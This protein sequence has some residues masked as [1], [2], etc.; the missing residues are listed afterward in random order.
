[1]QFAVT[2]LPIF[3]VWQLFCL[4]PFGLTK[5]GLKVSRENTHRSIVIVCLIIHTIIL[6]HGLVYSSYFIGWTTSK[7]TVLN[8]SNLISLTSTRS[9]TILIIIESFVK[10]STQIHFLEKIS[11]IDSILTYK[12]NI[13][14]KFD[15]YRQSNLIWSTIWLLFFMIDV[16]AVFVFV[17]LYTD[18]YFLRLWAA[19]AI[20]FFICSLRY[21]QMVTYV[22]LIRNRY[23]II[24]EVI[25]DI[26]K[27]NNTKMN[28][29]DISLT[30]N[31]FVKK[32]QS[33]ANVDQFII[34]KKLNDLREVYQLLYESTEYI[35]DIFRWSLPINI[36]IGFHEALVNTYFVFVCL[37]SPKIDLWRQ[38]AAGILTA[39]YHFMEIIA[40]SDTC[41][42][43]SEEVS[44][45]FFIF[46]NK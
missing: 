40:L 30:A 14:I 38:I 46:P 37:I 8:Y 3:R 42:Y 12:L 6:I 18:E 22:M 43:S 24:N 27:T 21:H 17:Y 2:L 25:R 35:N 33:T 45:Q 39:S 20:P 29:R 19:I 31:I 1:M 13:N 36:A 34:F 16:V 32:A 44:A 7:S 15:A 11:K 5:K 4:S 9:L 10:R 26:H 23:M 28:N 41:H